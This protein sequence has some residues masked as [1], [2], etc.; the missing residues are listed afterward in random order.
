MEGLL[1]SKYSDKLNHIIIKIKHIKFYF[2]ELEKL[3]IEIYYYNSKS[4]F[5]TQDFN[6]L[7]ELENYQVTDSN[8]KGSDDK[9]ISND[10]QNSL[11]LHKNKEKYKGNLLLLGTN[12]VGQY[13][14]NELSNLKV[15]L[16][17]FFNSKCTKK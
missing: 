16:S 3:L 15:L 9:K 2:V 14:P 10:I 4:Y 13:S 12:H 11:I 8:I 1:E 5:F 7:L 17:K 6:N